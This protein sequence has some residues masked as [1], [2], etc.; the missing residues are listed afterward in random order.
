MLSTRSSV[1]VVEDQVSCRLDGGLS[2][3]G[4]RS[5][6]YY[7]LEGV[8]ARVWELIQQPRRVEEVLAT[9]LAEY[10]VAPETC[11][12]DLLALLGELVDEGLVEVRA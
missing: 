6:A 3:L 11:E 9:L 8:G 2:V 7:G 4:I 10:D 5:G 12:R 1:V